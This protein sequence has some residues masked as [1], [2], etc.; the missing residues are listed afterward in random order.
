MQSLEAFYVECV[1]SVA[2]LARRILPPRFESAQ[3]LWRLEV[4]VVKH[5]VRLHE[6]IRARRRNIKQLQSE[7]RTTAA[8]RP[9]GWKGS[10]KLWQK[11][12]RLEK[13]RVAALKHVYNM[14]RRLGDAIAWSL[15]GGDR[16]K[17]LP[18]A[19]NRTNPPCPTGPSLNGLL[20]VAEALAGQTA[21]FPIIHDMT[22]ILRIG[23]LTLVG[24]DRAPTTIEVKT[25]TTPEKGGVRAHISMYGAFDRAMADRLNARLNEL[26]DG[27]P[28]RGGGV[29]PGRALDARLIRQLGRMREARE[30]Q[31]SRERSGRGATEHPA[32]AI[33]LPR[34]GTAYHWD[35]A[36]RVVGD[37]RKTGYGE[38]VV[39]Q[40]FVYFAFW[41]DEPLAYP[42][43]DRKCFDF[44]ADVPRDLV[45]SGIF[46]SDARKNA[47][48]FEANGR[49]LEGSPAP[50]ILPAYLQPLGSD[51]ILDLIYGRL[52]IVV[53]ANLG[54]IVDA[55]KERGYEARLP[56]NLKEGQSRF[57]PVWTDVQLDAGRRIQAELHNLGFFGRMIAHEFLSLDGFV[58][59]VSEMATSAVQ[60]ARSRWA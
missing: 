3:D 6:E 16:Q 47:L 7:I 21:G 15:L 39:D 58:E 35:V 30:R 38:A 9:V 48:W 54:R 5:Q 28:Q 11:E 43:S 14:S 24:P 12:L 29:S 49:D 31:E 8:A 34:R 10:L 51:T 55:V 44:L 56:E 59:I 41:R 23:D 13:A 45:D 46:Y 22:S 52:L 2:N 42:W 37:A 27:R 26:S 32:M 53:M 18:L 36:R 4:D 60:E 50:H 40:A 33:R 57:V 1:D 25:R 17:I 19:E 20:A